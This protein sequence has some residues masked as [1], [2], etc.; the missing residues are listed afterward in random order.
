MCL[1]SI[2]LVN[3]F[4]RNI[5]Q[6]LSIRQDVCRYIRI[7]TEKLARLSVTYFLIY[8][9]FVYCIYKDLHCL[10]Y[11]FSKQWWSAA[12]DLE[13]TSYNS[14]RSMKY[15]E[16]NIFLF[17]IMYRFDYYKLSTKL[18]VHIDMEI[19]YNKINRIIVAF[20]FFLII[21]ACTLIIIIYFRLIKIIIIF[22]IHRHTK[23][24]I[25]TSII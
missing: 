5:V 10:N 11:S 23:N 8:A 16:K 9:N 25:R 13:Q 15:S 7:V 17:I 24:N 1:T 3:K 6:I 22:L 12:S 18:I 2:N 20:L 19:V 21:D 14:N 4:T